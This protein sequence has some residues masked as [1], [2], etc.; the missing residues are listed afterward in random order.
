MHLSWSSITGVPPIQRGIH[1]RTPAPAQLKPQI[2]VDTHPHGSGG[3]PPLQRWGEF[4]SPHLWRGFWVQQ[5]LRTSVQREQSSPRLWRGCTCWGGRPN[6][7]I[8]E[9]VYMGS[10]DMGLPCTFK[11][12]EECL[13]SLLP[14]HKQVR[15]P[16]IRSQRLQEKIKKQ[17]W[18]GAALPSAL[19]PDREVKLCY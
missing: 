3:C 1:S 13:C 15:S 5:R 10:T 2:Q 6:P 17:W 14:T 18:K 11:S 16:N 19:T 4:S 8:S 9:S 12:T 7:R